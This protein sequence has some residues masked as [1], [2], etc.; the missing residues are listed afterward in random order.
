MDLIA[1][2]KSTPFLVWLSIMLI[3]GILL[4]FITRRR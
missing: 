4:F 1:F 2:L 3:C